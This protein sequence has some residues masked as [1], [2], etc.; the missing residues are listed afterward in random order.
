MRGTVKFYNADKG[1][2]FITRDDGERDVF[3]G[4]RVVEACGLTALR[5]GEKVDFELGT[6]RAGRAAVTEIE[7]VDD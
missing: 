2:G 1:F 7:L 3:V 5:E 4:S 6:D